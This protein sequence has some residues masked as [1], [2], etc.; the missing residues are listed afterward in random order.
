MAT[1]KLLL[2]IALACVA[3]VGLQTSGAAQEQGENSKHD[4]A[5]VKENERTTNTALLKALLKRRAELVQ[6]GHSRATH[7]FAFDFLDSRIAKLRRELKK[8]TRSGG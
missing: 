3:A 6:A 7:P 5:P 8:Q 4:S 1:A 2:G